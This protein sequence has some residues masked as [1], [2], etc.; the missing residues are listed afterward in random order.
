MPGE[1]IAA[2]AAAE[3]GAIAGGFNWVA[4]QAFV[5]GAMLLGLYTVF[6]G[7]AEMLHHGLSDIASGTIG[8][9]DGSDV[10]ESFDA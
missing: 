3:E 5:H 10:V 1:E 7:A 6:P 2:A 9:V 8:G 4:G